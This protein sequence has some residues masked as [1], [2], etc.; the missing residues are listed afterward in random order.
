MPS[1]FPGLKIDPF[2]NVIPPSA[3]E[4][5]GFWKICVSVWQIVSGVGRVPFMKY[6]RMARAVQ[7][8]N[9]ERDVC[10]MEREAHAVAKKRTSH[11]G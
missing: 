7:V 3:L 4:L 1:N 8:L 2:G 6:D 9:S 5:L 10:C 11:T